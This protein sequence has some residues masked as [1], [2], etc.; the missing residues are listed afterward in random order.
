MSDENGCQIPTWTVKRDF[1][2]E[3]RFKKYAKKKHRAELVSCLANLENLAIFL[4]H[5]GTL[6]QALGFGYFGSEGNDIYRIGQ[7]GIENAKET[8]LYIYARITGPDIQMIT[9]GDKQTQQEDIKLCK[10][11]T[12]NLKQENKTTK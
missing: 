5:G 10:A 6:Q 9:I 1:I 11:L 12:K 3:S 7:T 2:V 4:N 8:R